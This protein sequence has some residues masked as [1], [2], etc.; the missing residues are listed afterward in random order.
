MLKLA[1]K[2]RWW[3]ALAFGV[4][5]GAFA[6]LAIGIPTDVVPNPW[7]T[8][9]TPV[10]L[11]DYIFLALAVVLSIM[12]AASYALPQS[13]G[14]ATPQGKAATGGLLSVLAV[15]CPVCNKI[16]LL[17]LGTSGALTYFEPI[18]PLIGGLSL[19]LLAIA[20]YVRWKPL[21]RGSMSAET[22]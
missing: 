1:S 5:G 20:V 13:S 6:A 3:R 8:R 9:M 17:L 18:Q 7:F 2:K 12:L 16:A 15:G 11:Q 10:R 4:A 22:A 19:V 14:C 21:L